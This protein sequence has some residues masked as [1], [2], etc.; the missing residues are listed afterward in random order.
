MNYTFLSRKD[1]GNDF[2]SPHFNP[3]K[4]LLKP[5]LKFDVYI[6]LSNRLEVTY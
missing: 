5:N 4:L 3:L 6:F 2:V 1:V